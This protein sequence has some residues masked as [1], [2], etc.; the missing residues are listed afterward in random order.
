MVVYPK[1]YG[2]VLYHGFQLTDVCGPVD[3]L[4]VLTTHV[5]GISLSFIAEDKS[6]VSTFPREW[7]AKMGMPPFCTSQTLQ[8]THDFG[9]A[10]QMDVLIIPGGMG[11]FDPN[12]DN[13]GQP[14]AKVVDPIAKFILSQYPKL[15]Y[16]ITVCTGSGIAAQT[17][18]L[19]GK[20]ATTFKGAWKVIPLWRPT[21]QWVSKARWVVD[22][23]IWTSS[24]VCSGTDL[25]FGFVKDIYG[26]KIAS[27][28][29]TWME[30]T[31][32]EDP[33]LD[34]FGIDEKTMN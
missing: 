25:M 24:G 26:E 13:V 15:K 28:I 8:P 7:P 14:D 17:G 22:G 31:R 21:V 34:P 27:N 20:K 5:N 23:N 2:V 6:P 9:D 32:H 29:S 18:L 1:K 33:S 19:D 30:Y 12:P 16:L 11:V 4:N 10:P 3:V